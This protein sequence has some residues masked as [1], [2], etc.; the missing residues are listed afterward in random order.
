MANI[1][2]LPD[3][4]V[5]KIA[6]GE[7]VE[8]PASVVKELVENS[9]DA[10]STSI[11]IEVTSGGRRLIRVTD[12]GAGMIRDEALMALERHATSKIR[13]PEDI[14]HIETLGFRGEALPSIAAV[15]RFEL[16]T[17][18]RE[19]VV[20]TR[21]NVY[22]GKLKKVAEIGCPEGTTIEVKG[23]FFNTPAR[24]KFLK[25]RETELGRVL[26]VIQREAISNPSIGFTLISDERT[27]LRLPKRSSML[28][29]LEEIWRGARLYELEA[30]GEGV[31]VYG[32][33]SGPDDSRSTTQKLYFSVNKR[34]VRDKF[35]MRMVLDSYGRL[36]E[37]GRFPQGLINLDIPPGELDVNVHPA[38]TE[39]R[40]RNQR[41]V[42]D[43]IKAAVGGMVDKAPWTEGGYN[44][45]R[46][47]HAAEG[48][49][50]RAE[51]EGRG[52]SERAI[53]PHFAAHNLTSTGTP[54]YPAS[55]DRAGGGEEAA[56]MSGDP[57][58]EN[59]YPG[60]HDASHARFSPITETADQ[61]QMGETGGFASLRILGQIGRLY[62]VCES[63]RGAF[64]ID[65]HAAHERIN[66]EKIKRLQ[67]ENS[68]EVQELLIPAI[69][70][71]S[72]A[73]AQSISENIEQI[74]SLGI[75]IEGFGGNA[76]RVRALPAL[77]AGADPEKLLRDIAHEIGETGGEW[78]MS[79]RLDHVI[80]TMACHGSIRARDELNEEK[81]RALLE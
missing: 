22:G 67:S 45:A 36:I 13:N 51:G 33:L 43:L 19:A 30:E 14:L 34:A 42:G 71:S 49:A 69:I 24:H 37:K 1:R 50:R 74:R 17:K 44:G 20:G 4:V 5:S 35:V 80:A 70:D 63:P 62:I 52:A 72:P 73:E 78:S 54:Y 40:F 58:T 23:L 12:N 32:H 65:Q 68:M 3:E 59:A 79:R 60:G 16:I 2:I 31:R 27:A 64:I 9:I 75:S 15:S 66:Y 8:R 41:L 7:I 29:R 53:N 56:E 46:V 76:F 61:P 18:P 28:E 21:I 38:K 6:A 77:L 11:E 25:S 57:Y 10:G 81:M 47:R 26:D 55:P 39:V 48:F